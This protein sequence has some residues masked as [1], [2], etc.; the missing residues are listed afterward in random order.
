MTGI[1]YLNGGRLLRYAGQRRQARPLYT[2]TP[3]GFERFLR[4]SVGLPIDA[5]E[6]F[7]VNQTRGPRGDTPPRRGGRRTGE[8]IKEEARRWTGASHR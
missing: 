2:P 6:D 3:D 5:P 4:A 7:P 1:S 8:S